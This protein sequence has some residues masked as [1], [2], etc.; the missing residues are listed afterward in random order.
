[1]ENKE[2]LINHPAHYANHKIVL[3]PI[4]ILET[5]PFGIANIFKYIIR[6]KDKGNELQD[7]EKSAWYLE[8]TIKTYTYERLNNLLAPLY[9]FRF[10]ENLLLRTFGNL[11]IRGYP[12]ADALNELNT[13]IHTQ[14]FLLELLKNEI[15]K[16]P[17]EENP[18]EK[19]N[20][21]EEINED[22]NEDLKQ[23]DNE[24]KEQDITN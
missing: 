7:L 15:D 23:D 22:I 9:I 3:E 20:Q 12:P 19:S 24:E 14:I 21:N 10:S 1:M 11:L 17:T 4:D 18:P 2:D 5:L 8:R 6:A 16:E 13:E